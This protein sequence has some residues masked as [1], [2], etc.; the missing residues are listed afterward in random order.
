MERQKEI[1]VD[2]YVWNT[3]HDERVRDSHREKD[4]KTFKWSEPPADTGH[5]GEDF[6]C[7]CIGI[8][9]FEDSILMKYL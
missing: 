4:G 1:G 6:Q 5:P 7:R 2:S 8:P 3:A 9:V